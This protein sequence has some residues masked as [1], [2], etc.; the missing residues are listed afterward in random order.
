MQSESWK[1]MMQ[2]D[3]NLIERVIALLNENQIR[4]CVIGGQAVSAY[5]EPVISLD[6]DLAI[7]QN[8]FEQARALL[9]ETFYVRRYQ[10]WLS[11]TMA[12]SDF[13]VQIQTDAAYDAM[14]E[15]A[16]LR[17]VLGMQLPVANLDDLLTCKV[18]AALDPK[19]RASKRQKDLADI[20]RLL[21]VYPHLRERLPEEITTKLVQ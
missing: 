14:I 21:E 11:V 1:S 2:D 3:S 16:T 5:V 9:E 17:R 8:Q 18:D 10:P 19:R 7:A 4:Y 15:K 12:G 6:L 20:A 13:R